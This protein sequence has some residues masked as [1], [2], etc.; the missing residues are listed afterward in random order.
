MKESTQRMLGLGGM[1]SVYL[2]GSIEYG[3][4]MPSL[5]TYLQSL[6]GSQ[7][8]LGFCL[9]S[10]SSARLLALPLVGLWADRRT[11]KEVM[12][13]TLLVGA[14]GNLVYS[15]ADLTGH[16]WWMILVGRLIAGAGA[17]NGSLVAS[18]VQ[19]VCDE[20][21]RTGMNAKMNGIASIG[22][23]LGPALCVGLVAIDWQI[24]P[25]RINHY[26]SPGYLMAIV[27]LLMLLFFAFLFK[28]PVDRTP[29]VDPL[30]NPRKVYL[31]NCANFT[32]KRGIGLCFLLTFLNNFALSVLETI[33]TPITVGQFGW[34]QVANSI[35]FAIISVQSIIVVIGVVISHRWVS[36]RTLTLVG[37]I[38]TGAAQIIGVVEWGGA[39]LKVSLWS[40]WTAACILFVGIPIVGASIV[41][42]YSK[43]IE[44]VV[45]NGRQG[46]F[47]GI[48]LT[49]GAIA[50]IVGPILGG[51]GL[52]FPDK[53]TIFVINTCVW[54]VIMLL[55]LIG[56]KTLEPLPFE[57]TKIRINADI[58]DGPSERDALLAIEKYVDDD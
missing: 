17:A 33:A 30:F 14:I 38:F 54:G 9:A 22:L 56:Y 41:S 8:Q 49:F 18:Y 25:V 11:I 58:E 47:M 53:R 31:A 3:I 29:D 2:L 4:I 43:L 12:I 21:T 50:R 13:F 23:V 28:E 46:L 39:E 5:W 48:F 32:F 24:G 44:S 37:M 55:M 45:G 1:A 20:K 15:F 40:F 34:G 52:E 6:D 7:T 35:F 42:L 27:N 57:V 51:A 26:T 36:D 10:F 19:I 16:H